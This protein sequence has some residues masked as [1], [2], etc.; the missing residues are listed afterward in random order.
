MPGRIVEELMDTGG[1]AVKLFRELPRETHDIL[2]QIKQG[3]IR[4][5]FD[6]RGLEPLIQSMEHSANRLAVGLVAGSLVIGSSVM[7][8]LEA[9]PFLFGISAVGL[10]GILLAGLLG[11]YLFFR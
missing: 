3:K 2:R 7:I 4:A 1:D 10:A 8:G 9:R 11:V 6:H 5:T